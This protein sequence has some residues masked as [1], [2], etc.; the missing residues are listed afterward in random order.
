VWFNLGVA[1][2]ARGDGDAAERAYR[3]GL[4]LLERIP[5]AG[6]RGQIRAGA[7]TDLSALREI[8][9]SRRL[10]D[11]EDLIEDA[12]IRLADD[13][14]RSA[15]L[16]IDPDDVGDLRGADV[17]DL[18]LDRVGAFVTGAVPVDGLD[19]DTPV[20]VAWYFRTDDS[21]PFTQAALAFDTNTI[22]QD[23][24]VFTS[25]LPRANPAC[26]VAGEFLVR[27]YAGGRFLGEAQGSL[28]PTLV[29]T[30]FTPFADPIE[31]FEACVP[32]GF[33]VQRAAVSDSDSFTSF[34][35]DTTPFA[36]SV[37]VTPGA[38]LAGDAEDNARE[39]LGELVPGA[40]L[41]PVTFSGRDAE[42]NPVDDMDGLA[43]VDPDANQAVGLVFG[44]DSSSRTIAVIAPDGTDPL[45]LLHDAI[46]TITFTGVGSTS[47]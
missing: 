4:R 16:D 18:D 1:E 42:G 7:R 6:S 43:A 26:P 46:G 31:G 36:I 14:M 13:D 9:P 38:F 24:T 41:T 30:D 27:L 15:D 25:S 12:E 10:D 28:D 39:I 19:D 37:N 5:D 22:V 20:G 11:V 21:L 35:D 47:G 33:P 17:G 45:D 8:L 34:G 32:A 3:Q 29:G 44:P 23:G 40:E 2:V